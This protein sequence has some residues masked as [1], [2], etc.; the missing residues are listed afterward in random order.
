MSAVAYA[1]V[2]TRQVELAATGRFD[3]LEQL[4]EGE[5]G[6]H[7]LSTAD[8][9]GLCYAYSKTKRYDKLMPCLDRLEQNIKHGDTRSRL[10]G[11]DDAT[12]TVHIMRADALIELG[13]YEAAAREAKKGLDWLRED[14]SD[15]IDMV[16]NCLAGLSLA[17]TLSGDKNTGERYANEIW[18]TRAGDYAN[19]RAMALGRVH[20]A[21]GQYQRA[22]DG[23]NSDATFKAR[24]FLDNLFSG[25]LFRGVSNWVWAELPRAFMID[26]ALLET[27][28]TAEA[29]AG[30]DRLLAIP[31]TRN[32]GEIYW[33]MLDDRGRIAE[34]ENDLNGAIEFY[35]RAVDVVEQQR[36]TIHTETNK[37]GFV[38]DKQALYGRLIAAL[39]RAKR[40][41]EAYEYIERAKAR[42][43]VDVLAGR[44][45]FAVPK[46]A[47]VDV[48]KL[49]QQYREADRAARAQMPVDM[50][51]APDAATA[52]ATT[53]SLKAL[54]NTAPELASLVS[55]A[56]VTAAEIRQKLAPNEALVEYYAQGGAL[57]VA[58]ISA[59][60]M[61]VTQL[62][63]KGLQ[64]E[65]RKFR[66]MIEER[67]EGAPQQAKALYDRLLRPVAGELGQRSLLIIPHGVLHYL[68]FAALHDGKG[69]L[70]ESRAIHYLPNA[71]VLK[72]LRAPHSQVPDS[73]LVFGNPDLGIPQLDLPS[74]EVE[75]HKV[76]AMFP[77]GELLVRSQATKTAFKRF[78]PSFPYVHIAS[79][80]QFNP[81]DALTS[82]L[83]LRGDAENSSGSLTA[84]ELYTLRLDADLVTLSACETALGKVLKGDELV[85]LTRGFL[86][87]GSRNI[88]ASL[89]EV[90]DAATSELMQDFYTNL[91][92]KQNK[93]EALRAAQVSVL[94]K[95]P[96]PFF[97]AAFALTGQ[98]I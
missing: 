44:D 40:E 94:R 15:D 81:D 7:A 95:Y 14:Q 88:I 71:G 12:P 84:G 9:H 26:K 61:Q 83:L 58:V 76:A 47:E 45:D 36:S 51:R 43:L 31:Q 8:L 28:R 54:R 77:H 2:G 29:K 30:Y 11:L 79:H 22:L 32:N 72:Y 41:P 66:S 60:R 19:A 46:T 67:D 18:Q 37:I 69:Y 23:I 91:K 4:M 78:A 82:R 35:K 49:L 68:P 16:I 56:P 13:Q 87:A 27:G 65:V 53:L 25:A 96:H 10:F 74:A 50:T 85:G 80:G 17:A 52:L 62:D 1:D 59:G 73:I 42:A 90:D 92:A 20:I 98:G 38:G 86:Y 70:V 21:L 97:W 64:E 57:Y 39:Y 55:V 24:V 34:Q 33:L 89:W 6:K 93:M 3:L 48:S 5:Q 63:N 75:A